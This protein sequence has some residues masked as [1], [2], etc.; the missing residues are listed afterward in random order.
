MRVRQ[1]H[2]VI[3]RNTQIIK[4]LLC[5]LIC[6][7]CIAG[8]SKP[9]EVNFCDAVKNRKLAYVSTEIQ[10]VFP[11]DIPN[12]RINDFIVGNSNCPKVCEIVNLRS[13]LISKKVLALLTEKVVYER[14]NY[15]SGVNAK[16]RIEGI[17]SF[18]SKN[19]HIEPEI[20]VTQLKHWE[21]GASDS[22]PNICGLNDLSKREIHLPCSVD[23]A[24]CIKLK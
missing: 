24:T 2:Q 7:T 21:M 8:C 11:R 22:P 23:A 20:F 17:L 14:K 10:A 1:G 16:I 15:I 12:E 13:P 5:N 4:N 6:A 19:G 3:N 18:T 9:K